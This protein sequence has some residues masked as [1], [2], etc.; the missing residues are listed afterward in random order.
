M[1]TRLRKWFGR[2][3]GSLHWKGE[4]TLEFSLRRRIMFM[5]SMDKGLSRKEAGQE[6]VVKDREL[7]CRWLEPESQ[8]HHLCKL[9]SCTVRVPVSYCCITKHLQAHWLERRAVFVFIS[10]G[11]EAEHCSSTGLSWASRSSRICLWSVAGQLSSFSNLYLAF[12]N[13]YGLSLYNWAAKGWLMHVPTGQAE[14]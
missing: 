8:M 10:Q 11:S 6:W 14:K 12:P 5:K 3:W 1:L 4:Y 2:K 9:G 7:W 13:T